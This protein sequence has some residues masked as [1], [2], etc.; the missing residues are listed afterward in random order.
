MKKFLCFAAALVIITVASS[1][2][3]EILEA[4]D[5]IF[6][7]DT[8]IDWNEA[9]A[10]KSDLGSAYKN[11]FSFLTEDQKKAYNHILSEIM[12]ADTEFPELIQIPLMTGDELTEIIEALRSIDYIYHI[13]EMLP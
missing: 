1:H 3:T 8:V 11:H 9:S 10:E 4:V 7:S 13:E 6:S 5:E 12:N 2:K